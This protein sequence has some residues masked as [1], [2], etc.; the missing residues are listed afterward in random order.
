MKSFLQFLPLVFI[1][2]ACGGEDVIR[3]DSDTK[4]LYVDFNKPLDVE[5]WKAGFS[6][7][8][9]TETTDYEFASGHSY[10]PT[11]TGSATGLSVEAAKAFRLSSNNRSDDV[12]MFITKNY[13]GLEPNRL[14]DFD[15]EVVFATNA[16]KNCVGIGGAPGES[17]TIKAGATKIEPKSVN[18][19]NNSFSMNIDK[20][21]Q[22]L[23]GTD[24]IAIGNF[25]NDREC[26]NA[27]TNYMKKT[28]RSDR[29]RF[30]AYTDAQGK[31]WILFGTDSGFEGVTTIYFMQAKV[32]ATPR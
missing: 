7:Y 18:N 28:L 26:G 20:G 32:W 2:T 13:D 15:F 10:L 29:G 17:V 19:G 3:L 22:S 1:L 9:V 24:A 6:D 23:G 14:Y 8:T 11:I 25:A 21:N 27:D 16:Q 12:F 30:S 4:Q 31:I 5:G